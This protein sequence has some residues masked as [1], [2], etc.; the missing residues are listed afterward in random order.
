MHGQLYKM[1]L[2]TCCANNDEYALSKINFFKN[3]KSDPKKL[4]TQTETF[5]KF[6]TYHKQKKFNFEK[7]FNDLVPRNPDTEE[8]FEMDEFIDFLEEKYEI[9]VKPDEKG[10]CDYDIFSSMILI[11]DINII[12]FNKYKR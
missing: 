8:E 7:F 6:I 5:N 9:I 11:L 4:K 1:L 12:S 3:N 2:L 10:F